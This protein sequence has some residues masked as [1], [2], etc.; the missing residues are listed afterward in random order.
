MTAGSDGTVIWEV[1][2]GDRDA[3][4]EQGTLSLHLQGGIFQGE[5]INIHPRFMGWGMEE[6][7]TSWQSWGSWSL[8]AVRNFFLQ[9]FVF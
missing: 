1:R 9:L 5:G 6:G 8:A 2:S 4:T 7:V 3:F